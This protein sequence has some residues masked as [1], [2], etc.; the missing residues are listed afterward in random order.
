MPAQD[1]NGDGRADVFWHNSNNGLVTNWLGRPD[2]GFVSNDA[3]AMDPWA[4]GAFELRRFRR[5]RTHR[6]ADAR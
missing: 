4:T 2:G 5:R 3:N 6:R 1:F